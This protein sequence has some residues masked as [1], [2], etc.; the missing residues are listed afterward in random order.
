MIW[1]LAGAPS[2]LTTG[3]QSPGPTWWK[4]RPLQ[5]MLCAHT[6]ARMQ[7]VLCAHTGA[8]MPSTERNVKKKR[9]NPRPQVYISSIYSSHLVPEPWHLLSV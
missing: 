6:G 8:R 3:A 1:E 4:N 2:S 9:A 5:A 7:A